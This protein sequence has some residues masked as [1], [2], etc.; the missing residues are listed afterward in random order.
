MEKHVRD[1]LV[2]CVSSLYRCNWQS[3]KI[4]ELLLQKGF[5]QDVVDQIDEAG[6]RDHRRRKRVRLLLL[7]V[8]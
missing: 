1:Q 8:E 6:Y 4:K 3:D 7:V 5:A 2:Q